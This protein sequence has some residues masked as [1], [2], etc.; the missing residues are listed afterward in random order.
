M[1]RRG[2]GSRNKTPTREELGGNDECGRPRPDCAD[3]DERL[4]PFRPPN[5]VCVQGRG[6]RSNHRATAGTSGAPLPIPRPGDASS[7]SALLQV[8]GPFSVSSCGFVESARD[9]PAGKAV[10]VRDEELVHV[11]RSSRVKGGSWAV[12]QLAAWV[13][14]WERSGRQPFPFLLQSRRRCYLLRL[15]GI[16]IICRRVRWQV[17][18]GRPQESSGGCQR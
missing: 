1:L 6:A 15:A 18:D 17:G 4:P 10:E 9:G 3:Y 13:V 5:T 7:C 16:R 12:V 14:H 11:Y 2:A 8:P